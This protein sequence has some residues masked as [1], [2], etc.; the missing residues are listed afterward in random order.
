MTVVVVVCAFLS[1]LAW[2]AFPASPNCK[3]TGHGQEGDQDDGKTVDKTGDRRGQDRDKKAT[4]WDEAGYVTRR[5]K[6]VKVTKM[7]KR[8]K[9]T[10][11]KSQREDFRS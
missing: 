5:R 3:G 7:K 11:V 1:E 8:V 4:L 6:L 9:V 10:H 2:L